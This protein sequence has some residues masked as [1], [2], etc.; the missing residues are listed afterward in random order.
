MF[1]SRLLFPARQ[2]L[3]HTSVVL[4]AFNAGLADTST[5]DDEETTAQPVQPSLDQYESLWSRS[6][7]TTHQTSMPVSATVQQA[8][9]AQNLS[10]CGWSE[11]NGTTCAYLMHKDTSEVVIITKDDAGGTG[12]YQLMQ[13]EN[14]HLMLG[15]RALVQFRGQQAWVSQVPETETESAPA[16]AQAAGNS[17]P[18]QQLTAPTTTDSRAAHLRP[19]IILSASNTFQDSLQP[20]AVATVSPV[21]TTAATA[22]QPGSTQAPSGEPME[23]NNQSFIQRLRERN[24]HRYSSFPRPVED[25]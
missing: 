4:V 1:P 13:I 24:E 22:V 6:M 20:A 23:L 11:L 19:G 21:A 16:P 8:E 10:F 2:F 17:Q 15:M 3:L 18:P 9:W 14:A 25:R 7:F 12:D 5:P